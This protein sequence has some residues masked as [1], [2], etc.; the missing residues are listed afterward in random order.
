M[1]VEDFHDEP[2]RV[3][4]KLRASFNPTEKNPDPSVTRHFFSHLSTNQ[5]IL[6]RAGM[7]LIAVVHGEHEYANSRI[8]EAGGIFAAVRNKL[9]AETG[10]GLATQEP[11]LGSADQHLL[12]PRLNAQ[13]PLWDVFT[14]KL[15]QR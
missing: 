6:E 2:D 3:D 4:L 11:G 9:A 10:W 1:R 14:R 15:T 12:K 5:I 8:A 13:K 7:L